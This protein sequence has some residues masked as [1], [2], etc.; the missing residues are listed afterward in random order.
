MQGGLG[1][2]SRP[3]DPRPPGLAVESALRNGFRFVR[4][5]AACEQLDRVAKLLGRQ[6]VSQRDVGDPTAR[7]QQFGLAG[8]LGKGIIDPR[9]RC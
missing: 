7:G 2:G 4:H 8:G 6:A 1:W 5:G 9:V 3:N